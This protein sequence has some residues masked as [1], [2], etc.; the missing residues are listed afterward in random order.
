MIL[1]CRGP[2]ANI[3]K[4][5]QIFW[6]I[7]WKGNRTNSLLSGCKE[8]YSQCKTHMIVTD[9]SC[10]QVENWLNFS[11]AFR[12]LQHKLVFFCVPFEQLLN[13]SI[14]TFS[15]T[16]WIRF[17]HKAPTHATGLLMTGPYADTLTAMSNYFKYTG[18]GQSGWPVG[19]RE[20]ARESERGWWNKRKET[21]STFFFH[22]SNRFALTYKNRS[23]HFMTKIH[24]FVLFIGCL[25][26]PCWGRLRSL[27]A[28]LSPPSPSVCRLGF[29]QIC[30]GWLCYTT[31][32]V[33]AAVFFC[34]LCSFSPKIGRRAFG[35]QLGTM[36]AKSSQRCW[37]LGVICIV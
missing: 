9:K 36:S 4:Y 7:V 12:G 10:S 22:L 11:V 34:W 28:A 26:S 23:F 35:L 13:P 17:M 25:F 3:F 8:E 31:G 2:S 32:L 33:H 1:P 16:D 27:T 5:I 29:R 30:L 24:P 37:C 6:A 19:G 15:F 20:G 18:E 21:Q 14:Y